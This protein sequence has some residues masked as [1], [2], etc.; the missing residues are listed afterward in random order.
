MSAP[1]NRLLLH[2]LRTRPY[3]GYRVDRLIHLARDGDPGLA[4]DV[5]NLGIPQP[6]SIVFERQ[7]VLLFV[8]AELTQA[9]SVR[10]RAQAAKLFEAERRLQFIRNL[11]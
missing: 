2:T 7:V 3:L 9:V 6:R 11:E 4:E 1:L 10:K 5:R 8:D